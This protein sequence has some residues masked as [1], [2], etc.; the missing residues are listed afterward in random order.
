SFE[1]RPATMFH[2]SGE[3]FP[4]IIWAHNYY[5]E[6]WETA[7][8]RCQRV[9]G[10]FERHRERGILNYLTTGIMNGEPVVCAT[11]QEAEL[12]SRLLYQL[13]PG[14]NPQE[15]L[16]KLN[17]SLRSIEEGSYSDVC[18]DSNCYRGTTR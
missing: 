6:S 1:R 7:L 8:A 4:V 2:T 9:S 18:D 15:E 11:I 17:E 5:H 10:I 3:N 13:E 14:E 16:K 12:C